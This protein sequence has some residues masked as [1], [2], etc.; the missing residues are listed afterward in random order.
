LLGAQSDI[1]VIVNPPDQIQWDMMLGRAC[2]YFASIYRSYVPD[3]LAVFGYDFHAGLY[4]SGSAKFG[5]VEHH[6][7]P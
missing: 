6:H 2:N 4:K 1:D 5:V 7:L 3:A